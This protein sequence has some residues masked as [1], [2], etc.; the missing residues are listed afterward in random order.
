MTS[1]NQGCHSND[2]MKYWFILL[3]IPQMYKKQNVMVL[4]GV[5]NIFQTRSLQG[6]EKLTLAQQVRKFPTF[7]GI[8]SFVT[9]LIKARNWTLTWDSS[10]IPPSRTLFK[11]NFNIIP[12]YAYI[13]QVVSSLQVLRPT[14]CTDFSSPRCVLCVL[15]ISSFISP[16]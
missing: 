5:L 15:P 8:K 13:S 10:S 9:E 14:F 6:T 12:T 3:N 1:A 16:F 4:S 2:Y 7:Y 11:I